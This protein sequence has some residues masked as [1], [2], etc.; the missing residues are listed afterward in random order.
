MLNC[1]NLSI[2]PGNG[3]S[4]GERLVISILVIENVVNLSSE[5]LA[6]L[7]EGRLMGGTLAI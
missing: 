1:S 6:A 7:E 2:A 4:K 5:P 3:I